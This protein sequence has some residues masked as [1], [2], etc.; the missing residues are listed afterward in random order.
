MDEDKFLN[1]YDMGNYW[2]NKA[3][4]ELT[5]KKEKQENERK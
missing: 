4:I 5:L 1:N 3:V 2:D